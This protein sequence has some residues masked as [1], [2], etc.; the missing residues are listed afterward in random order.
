MHILVQK[1]KLQEKKIWLS[2]TIFTDVKTANYNIWI[3][4][5]PTKKQRLFHSFIK[6]IVELTPF[7]VTCL[8][9]LFFLLGGI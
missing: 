1:I 6:K 8:Q 7:L 2:V 4:I 3:Y 9:L 5:L